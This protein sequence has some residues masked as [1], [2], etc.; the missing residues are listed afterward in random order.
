MK[1]KSKRNP[2]KQFDRSSKNQVEKDS[3]KRYPKT[4]EPR[5]VTDTPIMKLP[6][7]DH[8]HQEEILD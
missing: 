2:I 5:E 3:D 7:K 4:D 6:I 8:P 1:E